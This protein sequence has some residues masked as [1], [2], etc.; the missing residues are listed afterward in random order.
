MVLGLEPLTHLGRRDECVLGVE[1]AGAVHRAAQ[2]GGRRMC[3]QP[4][5]RV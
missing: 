1:Q 4:A 3:G 2:A 5:A